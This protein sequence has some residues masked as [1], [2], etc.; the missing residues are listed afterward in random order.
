MLFTM[1]SWCQLFPSRIGVAG[2]SEPKI[3]WDAPR[4][5]YLAAHPMAKPS[6]ES[7]T[8]SS[9]GAVACP[10]PQGSDRWLRLVGAN[11][12]K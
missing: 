2:G 5:K 9:A 11:A 1:W 4:L 7:V 6:S 3:G 8:R 12:P 10:L